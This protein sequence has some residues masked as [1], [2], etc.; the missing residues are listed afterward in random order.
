[1]EKPQSIVQLSKEQLEDYCLKLMHIDNEKTKIIKNLEYSIM[2]ILYND[3]LCDA[4]KIKG[5][6]RLIDN[7]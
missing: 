4:E 5:I 6:R 1:M 2:N 7:D 3:N